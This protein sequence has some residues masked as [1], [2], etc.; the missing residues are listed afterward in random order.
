MMHAV[1]SQLQ[2][3]TGNDTDSVHD[4]MSCG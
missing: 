2:H 1:H 3:A 4:T